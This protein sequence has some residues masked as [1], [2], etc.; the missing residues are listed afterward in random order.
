MPP[1]PSAFP[2]IPDAIR[3]T[4]AEEAELGRLAAA[5]LRTCALSPGDEVVLEDPDSPEAA[6]AGDRD[7][8]RTASPSPGLAARVGVFVTLRLANELRGCIGTA[9]GIEPL[10]LAV[11][12]LAQA[13]ACRDRRFPPLQRKELS[14]IAIEITVLGAPVLL[15]AD[16]ALILAGLI[17]GR[18]GVR[19]RQGDRSGLLLP[20]VAARFDWGAAELLEQVSLKAGLPRD[21]W[22]DP[23]SEVFAFKARSFEA[24][25]P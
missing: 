14:G 21:G 1:R 5:A 10:H 2:E 4:A 20:Q 17:P 25:S 22:K 7:S 6:P 24:G 19:I 15:P 16:L 11:S 8:P 13:A 23:V 9:E 3:L 18:H 12:R